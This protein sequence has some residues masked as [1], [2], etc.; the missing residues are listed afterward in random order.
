M[1][2]RARYGAAAFEGLTGSL[3][4]PFPRTMG[5][6]CLKYVQQ[7]IESGLTC[8]MVTRFEQA[9]ARELGVKHCIATPGCTPA[10]AALAAAFAFEPGVEY[11]KEEPTLVAFELSE[12]EGGVLLTVTESGFDRIPL[13]R[14][15]EA[16]R[17]NDQG[18]T[19]QM[20]S[21]AAHVARAR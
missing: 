14:R 20:K 9:F 16:L 19:E 7:V 6:N 11:S 12:A 13:H 1:S 18:W 8:D 3:P 15:A 5:P 17:M 4:N 21:V 2:S 10:L